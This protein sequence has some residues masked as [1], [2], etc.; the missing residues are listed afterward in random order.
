MNGWFLWEQKWCLVRKQR[1]GDREPAILLIR[2]DTKLKSVLMES[3]EDTGTVD[4]KNKS[5]QENFVFLAQIYFYVVNNKRFMKWE[6]LVFCFNVL[7][8]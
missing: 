6:R 2:R 4:G 7:V 1:S 5:V 8:N 3:K